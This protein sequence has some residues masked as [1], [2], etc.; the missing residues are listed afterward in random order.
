MEIRKILVPLGGKCAPSDAGNADAAMLR[1]SLGIAEQFFAEVEALSCVQTLSRQEVRTA[2][3]LPTY[4]M[5]QLLDLIEQEDT[6]R[7]TNARAVFEAV[8]SVSPQ[9]RFVEARGSMESAL[10]R[11]GR[12][13]DL[14]VL[15]RDHRRSPLAE[16][17][18][19][20]IGRPFLV[21]GA[22]SA[23]ALRGHLAL[24]WNDS[25]ESSRAISATIGLLRTADRVTVIAC[26]EGGGE[27]V[28][29]ALLLDY[30]TLHEVKAEPISLSASRSESARAI[31]AAA[32]DAGADLIVMG[33]YSHHR[34]H[35]LLFG[36][37][38]Q[39]VLTET[40]LPVLIVP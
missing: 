35:T 16:T 11:H 4:G 31:C 26:T 33:G 40:G 12:V 36:S 39:H 27:P 2:S 9:A 3:W 18:I 15:A 10:A 24:A 5:G 28:D 25:V 6:I 32:T 1:I 19:R 17:A 7:R 37:M 14:I 30:L 21:T 20:G 8:A 34:A 22:G 13:S 23:V 38:T 29:P